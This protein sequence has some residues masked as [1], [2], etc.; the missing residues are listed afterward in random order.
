MIA[1]YTLLQIPTEDCRFHRSFRDI[2]QAVFPNNPHD[3]FFSTTNWFTMRVSIFFAEEF[4]DTKGAIRIRISKKNRQQTQWAKEKVQKDKQRST[5]HTYK[6]KDRVT[7]TALKTGGET[8]SQRINDFSVMLL[9]MNC[10][11]TLTYRK[12]RIHGILKISMLR[13]NRYFQSLFCFLFLM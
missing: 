3:R 8:I 5:K 10:D 13:I 9:V 11:S 7:R 12:I 2:C 4:E 1:T 6:T